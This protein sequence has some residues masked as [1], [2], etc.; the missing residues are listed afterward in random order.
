MLKLLS[1]GAAAAL[2]L[3]A[4]NAFALTTPYSTLGQGYDISYPQCGKAYPSGGFGIIGIDHGRPFDVDNQY[5]PNPCLPAEYSNAITTTHRADLYMNTGYD[6]SYWTNHQVNAC[7]AQMTSHYTDTDHQR[8]WEI[9]CA[10]AWFNANYVLDSTS[11]VVST[12]YGRHGQNLPAPQM[13]WLDVE[14]GNSWSSSDLTLNAATLQGAVDEL[15][16][17][18]ATSTAAVGA[19]STSYQWGQIAGTTYVSGLAATWV[20]TG[21]KSATNVKK[22][23]SKNF[24][25]TAAWLVQWVWHNAYD[26]DV[27]C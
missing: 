1:A 10:T 11:T 4:Q 23:C 9:G 24:D 8:A 3:V 22:Y 5:G 20:A 12:A 18:P 25:Q 13:W 7:T 26:Y 6:P 14:T 2:A 21:Q 16:A 27:P 17:L 15:H 19:Y